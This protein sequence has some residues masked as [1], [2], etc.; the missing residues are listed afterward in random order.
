MSQLAINASE[1]YDA[2]WAHQNGLFAQVFLDTESMDSQI[3]HLAETLSKSNPEAMAE[4]KKVFWDG[5][6]NWDELLANRAEISGNL[7]TSDFT[8][9]FIQKFKKK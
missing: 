6:E 3:N 7:V 4:L 2:H 9:T 1:F 5:T 8:K